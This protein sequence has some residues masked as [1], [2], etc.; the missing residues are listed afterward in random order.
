MAKVKAPSSSSEAKK[1]R[2]ALTPE[3]EENQMIALA[4]KLVKQRLIDGTATSQETTHFLKLATKKNRL[5]IERL[6]QEN[7]LIAAKTEAIESA[8]RVEALYAD[9]IEAMKR[10]SGHGGSQ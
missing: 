7:K 10:Y 5:E 9:A 6:E 1:I 4:T 8:K 2:P 3:A